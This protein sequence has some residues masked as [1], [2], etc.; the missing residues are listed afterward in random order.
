[1]KQTYCVERFNFTFTVKKIHS[2][3]E[4]IKPFYAVGCLLHTCSD[5]F[6]IS[7]SGRAAAEALKNWDGR[8]APRGGVRE[9]A[10]YGVTLEKFVKI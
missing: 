7:A 6:H 10:S 1:M 2:K 4:I 3:C 5:L 8:R 9:G